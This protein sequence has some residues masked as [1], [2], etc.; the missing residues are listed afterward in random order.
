MSSDIISW[1]RFFFNF[2]YNVFY[3]FKV[4]GTNIR[5][6]YLLILSSIVGIMISLFRR[7]LL[8]PTYDNKN[9]RSGRGS[10]GGESG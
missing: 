6:I 9:S 8:Q 2:I 7:M 3:S 5:L 10:A 1:F 4:P